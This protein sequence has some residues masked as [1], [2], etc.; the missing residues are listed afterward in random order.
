MPMTFARPLMVLTVLLALAEAGPAAAQIH[1]DGSLGHPA[2]ALTGPNYVIP[3]SLGLL[4][5]Q[6]LFQSFS[7]FNLA[8]GEA[9]YFTTSSSGI[10]NI[11]SRVTGGSASLLN[12]NINVV[13]ASGAP[14]F[15]FINPAGVTFGNGA[16]INVPA[17]LHVST[18]SYVKF[19]DGRF[20]SDT[21]HV[22]T[23]SALAPEAFGFLGNSRATITVADGAYLIEG[24]APVSVV[25]GD[26]VVDD[27]AIGTFGPGDVRVAAV[28]MDAVEVP[29][30]GPL[31]PGHGNLQVTNG[32]N[33]FTTATGQD[34]GNVL[35]SAGN[36]TV[37]SQGSG[38]FTG[39]YSDAPQGSTGN[40]GSVQILA[41]GALTLSNVG[42]ITATTESSG[43]VGGA[44]PER[45]GANHSW[46]PVRDL[47]HLKWTRKYRNLAGQFTRAALDDGGI[48]DL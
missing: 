7:T 34:G 32:A 6:N 9:A 25:A 10:A 35:V 23:F 21:A 12:G 18:A 14:N 19:P 13:A 36:I 8:S 47:F 42:A 16:T 3:Q 11:I 24:S 26:I 31:P 38:Y 2:Q 33:I 40:A 45:C 17:A 39:I 41:S 37:D 20:Y 5:G 22:S 1:T 29:F 27:G 46:R 30:S 44:H 28:G 15:F 48:T 43:N 4:S